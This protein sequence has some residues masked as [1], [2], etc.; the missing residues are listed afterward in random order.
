MNDLIYK[1]EFVNKRIKK[2][3][4]EMDYQIHNKIR[5]INLK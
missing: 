4:S 1:C 3:I 5:D 2:K